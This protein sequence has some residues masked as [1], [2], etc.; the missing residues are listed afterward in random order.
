MENQIITA[1]KRFVINIKLIIKLMGV[2]AVRQVSD[3]QLPSVVFVRFKVTRHLPAYYQSQFGSA[4]SSPKF[5]F[6]V[7]GCSL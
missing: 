1:D 7:T 4:T 6:S 5:R 2:L 3:V